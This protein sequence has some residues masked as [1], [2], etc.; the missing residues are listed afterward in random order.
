MEIIKFEGKEYPTLLIKFPFGVRQISTEELNEDLMN[1]DGSYVSDNARVVD[2]KIFYYVA[3]EDLKL[4]K[5][6]LVQQI[7]SEI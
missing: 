4:S 5:T 7:L 6:R 1:I 3:K 2:E